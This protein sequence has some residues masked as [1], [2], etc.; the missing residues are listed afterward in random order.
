LSTRFDDDPEFAPDD[1]LVV[2]LRP[3]ADHLGPPPGRYEAI[4]RTAARRRLLRAAA[5]VGLSCVVAVLIALPLH[6]VTPKTPAPPAVPLAP[7]PAGSPAGTPT[8]PTSP[9]PVTSLPAPLPTPDESATPTRPLEPAGGP[10]G[11]PS[12]A[13]ATPS[14][15]RAVPSPSSP[16]PTVSSGVP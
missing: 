2:L 1:P 6:L 16:T 15:T 3:A 11:E 8:P 5:G 10:P 14:E 12:P 9:A 13:R 4:R 7:P